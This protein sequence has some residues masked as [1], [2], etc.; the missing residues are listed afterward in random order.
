MEQQLMARPSNNPNRTD[1]GTTAWRPAPPKPAGGAC[2][3]PHRGPHNR[4]QHP[5]AL[6][7]GYQRCI[8]DPGC[9]ILIPRGRSPI[10]WWHRDLGALASPNFAYAELMTNA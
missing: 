4:C 9:A 7:S 3:D 8:G 6:P 5:T 1:S 2:K 10:C